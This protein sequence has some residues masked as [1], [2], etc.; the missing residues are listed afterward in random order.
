MDWFIQGLSVFTVQ[1]AMLYDFQHSLTQTKVCFS[2]ASKIL[3][4]IQQVSELLNVMMTPWS[5][6]GWS[7]GVS[8]K[9]Y[10]ALIFGCSRQPIKTLGFFK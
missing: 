9:R 6:G 7:E 10:S 1:S 4:K 5:I 3:L 8:L 2:L